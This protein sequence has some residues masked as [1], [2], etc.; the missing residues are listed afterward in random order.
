MNLSFRFLRQ[1][2]LVSMLFCM[3]HYLL[4]QD[5][6][7]TE[8]VHIEPYKALCY[9]AFFKSLCL[10]TSDESAD[11]IENFT[12]EWGFEYDLIV[13]K[14][15]LELPPMDGSSIEFKLNK[16]VTKTAVPEGYEF[17]LRLENELFLGPGENTSTFKQVNDSIFL[18]MDE[19]EILVSD[20]FKPA[21]QDVIKNK[22]NINAR[23]TFV[24]GKRIRIVA[25]N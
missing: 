8:K 15:Q 6:T 2:W 14:T 7:T 25:L 16:V 11:Y 18:Y 12:F 20:E 23:C 5:K 9:G 3:S 21:I 22:G 1:A 17:R 19:I 10:K 13:Y 4:A 24:K